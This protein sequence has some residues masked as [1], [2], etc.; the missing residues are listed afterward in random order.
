MTSETNDKARTR[1]D[2]K[3]AAAMREAHKL[4]PKLLERIVM[5]EDDAVQMKEELAHLKEQI[6]MLKSEN[7]KLHDRLDALE[8]KRKVTKPTDGFPETPD[9]EFK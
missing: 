3:R 8:G 2:R 1:Y 7:R 9:G 4:Q 6:V 5:L